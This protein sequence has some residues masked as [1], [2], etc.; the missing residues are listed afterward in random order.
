MFLAGDDDQVLLAA[1]H[2]Q[3]AVEH[4]AEIAGAVPASRLPW[5]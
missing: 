4:E 5:W 1:D 3:L 2:K